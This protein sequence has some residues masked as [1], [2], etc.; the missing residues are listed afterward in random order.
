MR[1]PVLRASV[2]LLAPW[3]AGTAPAQD[4]AG[5]V[6]GRNGPEAG[7]WVIAET[8]DLPTRYAK[9][10]VTNDAGRF[11]IPDL[12]DARYQVWVRGY[13]LADSARV[14][15]RPGARL[16]L[17]VQPAASA[18]QAAQL[19]PSMYW[20]AMIDVPALGAFPGT[21]PDGNGMPV[22]MHTQA[23]WLDTVKNR[24][25]S[26]HLFGTR[27]I[28]EV[29]AQFM[30]G[31]DSRGAWALRTVAGQAMNVMA[32][33]L[34]GLGPQS[35]YDIFSRW[36]DRIAAGELPSAQP[37]RPAG[38]ERNVVITM[39]DWASP[40]H[41]QHD[42]ISTDKRHP[43]VNANGLIYGSPEESTDLVPTLDPVR[44]VASTVRHPFLD[45]RT[46]SSSDLPHGVSAYW[47]D[48]AIWD[49][50][51][52]IHNVMF[53]AFGKV[54]FTARIRPEENPAFC[55]A[56]STHPSAIADP[57]QS[58]VRQLS[59][60]D[61]VTG[62]EVVLAF[63]S[64]NSPQTARVPVAARSQ[65]FTPLAGQCSPMADAPGSFTVTLAPLGFAVCAAKD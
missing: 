54:W 57:Q 44:N 48:E 8:R 42:A 38:I 63:N 30:N 10:V 52:S 33:A 65:N 56:G 2:L 45:P 3:L 9:V 35:A 31:T 4:I 29:P 49:G 25:Q 37:A 15:A 61:P 13:G 28:R 51:T 11:D 47:G 21:G 12:P 39:W 46:P 6:L 59:R 40:K 16:D 7:A 64:A 32:V 55:R 1:L 23:Q 27:G 18:A 43:T 5:R 50:H 22:S 60:F 41:Y 24:C 14:E 17:Q 58:S 62:R 20:Y 36:T 26:C 19:Y 34:G 53:D